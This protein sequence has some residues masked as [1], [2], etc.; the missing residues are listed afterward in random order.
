MRYPLLGLLIFSAFSITARSE[1][2]PDAQWQ[3]SRSSLFDLVQIGYTIV[4]VTSAPDV[5]GDT[6]FLQKSTDV[7]KCSET[8]VTDFK[9]KKSSSLL[10][11]WHLVS[12]YAIKAVK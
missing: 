4:D 8:H 7:Y 3:Y 9:N 6:Y 2:S 12:P 5:G 1:E 10:M 11:C